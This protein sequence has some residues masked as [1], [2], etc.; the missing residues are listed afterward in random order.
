MEA[1]IFHMENFLKN[2]LSKKHKCYFSFIR[3]FDKNK[4]NVLIFILAKLF[5]NK[6]MKNHI[7]KVHLKDYK[8]VKNGYMNLDL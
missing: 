8:Y 5:L 4:I 6:S 7:L 1:E 3:M 2:I